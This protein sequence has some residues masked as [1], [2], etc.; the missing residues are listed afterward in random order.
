M[1]D[2]LPETFDEELSRRTW[3]DYLSW[4]HLS[5]GAMLTLGW[6]I[7]EIT[8]R[9][10]FGIVVA[11]GKFGWNDF[12]TAH[13]LLRTDPDQPRGRTC[14]WFYVA[15]GLWKITIA[16]FLATGTLLIL[17][18]ALND[19]PP[20]G[21]V[22]VGLTAAMGVTLLAVI[23][24]IGV[25]NARWHGVR[26]WVDASLHES[27]KAD[28]WP[29]RPTGLNATMGL[30]FPALMVPIVLTSLVTLHLGVVPMLVS[31]FG[32]GIFI[33]SLFRGVCA[34]SP[35]DC[36]AVWEDRANDDEVA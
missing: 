18:V 25:C 32:E 4:G 2:T 27:R 33:W 21:L 24:L 19:N 6:L 12:L 7:Y 28:L 13:W 17:M 35:S 16:A 14:F 20:D 8:A 31:V 3:S 22:G 15:N 10:S 1:H 34:D 36:W 9:P 26:V 29:P 30:L 5:W 23:P 11:C